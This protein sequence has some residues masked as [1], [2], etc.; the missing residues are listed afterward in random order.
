MPY[1]ITQC[2]LPPGRG[3]IPALPQPKLV[4]DLATPER[5]KAELTWVVGCWHGYLSGARC[6][7]AYVPARRGAGRGGV[8]KSGP[9]AT[10]KTTCEIRLN[11]RTFFVVRERAVGVSDNAVQ[12]IYTVSQKRIPD[13][14]S[15]NSSKH[16]LI[17]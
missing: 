15:C 7:L 17:F 5:C 11:L 16:C 6:R 8:Q 4:L 12:N 10:A 1:R 13:I 9:P 2:Y 3:D 14:F